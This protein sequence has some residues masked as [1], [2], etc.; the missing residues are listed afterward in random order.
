MK[1]KIYSL[2]A[3]TFGFLLVACGS[4]GKQV[5][6][7]ST[8]AIQVPVFDADSAYAYIETQVA[9]GPRVPN[10]PQH[11]ACGEFLA[12][13]LEE[14]GAKVTN[15]YADLIAFDGTV[16]KARN[17]IGAYSPE[18]KKRMAL[19]AHWD[20]RKW[21]DADPDEKNWN[22]PILGANDAAS[23]VGVLLE[24]ARAIRDNEPELG[25]DIIF[26][27]TEDYGEPRFS[28]G[29]HLDE[30]WCLG[31][32][33]WSRVPHAE[34]YNARFGILLDMVGGKDARFYKE[35]YSMKFARDICQKVWTKAK[36]IGYSDYFI[37]EQKGAATDDHLFVNEIARIKTIDIIPHSDEDSFFA[38]WHTVNDTMENIDRNTLRAVGE[39]ILN[40]LYT[41]K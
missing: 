1:N 21:A 16:L 24:I 31:S 10:T 15:Q 38:F 36:E 4:N 23:G 29:K 2:I 8:E 12:N 20:T 14:F 40:V 9:F 30:Y 37:D 18:K 27:D 34:G 28:R 7:A 6:A 39:T 25:V 5:P 33:Y 32:Q 3:A 41:E 19:F 22:T 17:I 13:K 26:F 35:Y 11:V